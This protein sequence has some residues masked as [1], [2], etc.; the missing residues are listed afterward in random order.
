MPRRIEFAFQR[1]DEGRK[2]I[3]H[4]GATF[5]QDH[6]QLGIDAGI[7]HH[8]A[9]LV[10]LACRAHAQCRIARFFCIINERHAVGDEVESTELREQAMPNRFSGDTGSIGDVEHRS[11]C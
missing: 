2:H 4:Q 5:G 8:R 1:L 10:P 3:Q 11:N 9:H 6:A 7:D